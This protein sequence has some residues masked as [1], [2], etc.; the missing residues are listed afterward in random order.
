MFLFP[1]LP[2]FVFFEESASAPY[3]IRKIEEIDKSPAGEVDVRV[4]CFYRRRDISSL[5]PESHPRLLF[6]VHYSCFFTENVSVD[7]LSD[8]QAHQLDQRELFSSHR[9][10]ILQATHIRGKCNVAMR[11]DIAEENLQSLLEK[12]DTF[13]YQFSYDPLKKTI[14]AEKGC[15]RVG[16]DFQATIPDFIGK[17]RISLMTLF[18]TLVLYPACFFVSCRLSLCKCKSHWARLGNPEVV[19]FP[20]FPLRNRL[21][22]HNGQSIGYFRAC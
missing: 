6:V 14:Q 2:D 18:F 22:P 7:G 8:V 9:I 4:K 20:S 11:D 19:T 21:V 17:Q 13:F 16:S 15:I 10:E 3:Q 5:L 12:E 1:L